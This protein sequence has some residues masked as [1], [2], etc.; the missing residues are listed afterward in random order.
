M[1]RRAA[2]A[3]KGAA[4]L[5]LFATTSGLRRLLDGQAG[6]AGTA[7]RLLLSP[8]LEGVSA[9]VSAEEEGLRATAH[10]LRVPGGPR[11]AAFAPTL[12]DR[13]PRDAAGFLA[14]PG[15]DAFAQIAERAGGASV[16]AGLE[17]ALPA[18]AGLELADLIAPL[19]GEAA[20]TVTA[21]E[22]AP[23]FTLAAR[24]R[25]RA[26]TRESLARLQ[27]PVSER[28]GA[29]AFTQKELRGT[30]AFTLSVTPELE[31]SYAV[32]KDAL[33]ASTASSGLEQLGRARSPVTGAS[34][35]KD[36]MPEEGQKVEALGF[37]D[38]RQLLALGE[39]TGLKALS[40]PAA[41]D[42]LGRIRA[43]A[44]P[45]MGTR[46]AL[47]SLGGRRTLEIIAPDPAQTAF[48]FQIDVRT[49][50]DPRLV[51]WAAATTRSSVVSTARSAGLSVSGPRDGSRVRPDGTTL[52][53]RSAGVVTDFGW[54][55]SIP[56]RSSSSGRRFGASGRRFADRCRLT[57][58]E[59]RHPDPNAFVACSRLSRSTPRSHPRR[60]PASAR[61]SRRRRAR[62]AS[63]PEATHSSPC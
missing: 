41:R 9:Q 27:A 24:T 17:D 47:V 10:V 3:R 45:G 56:C 59:V 8:R 44:H 63:I 15:L 32:S 48:N 30:D 7:G 53:W 16:L 20:L 34:V 13:V 18:A 35:L 33:V 55:R 49:L 57:A 31:P 40:S 36:L 58:F 22:A 50:P 54:E 23:V 12:A 2:E 5:D 46:N 37:L 42:D 4:S 43:A 11:A 28:L 26:S 38:P 51:T 25:D 19:D 29:G 60:R 14:V 21:G 6:A 62:S 39:R 52:R 61:C 1:F